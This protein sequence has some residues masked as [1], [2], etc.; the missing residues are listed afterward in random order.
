MALRNRKSCMPETTTT[1]FCGHEPLSMHSQ[2]TP[3]D[4]GRIKGLFHTAHTWQVTGHV[5]TVQR[6][7]GT[8]DAGLFKTVASNPNHS[9]YQ[10]LPTFKPN[11]YSLRKCG[12]PFQLPVIN[13]TLL[14]S[15][16]INRCLFQFV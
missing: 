8:A 11:Q 2:C 14:K 12:H 10:N 9:L 15:T 3:L 5:Y 6:L 13:T 16:F 4:I 1:M 7:D